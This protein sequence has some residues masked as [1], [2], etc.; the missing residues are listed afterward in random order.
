MRPVLELLGL[1]ALGC[2]CPALAGPALYIERGGLICDTEQTVCLRGNLVYEPNPRLL[3]LRARVQFAPGP[4]ELRILMTGTNRSGDRRY[5]PME[6][7]LRGKY[8]EIVDFKMIPD[9]PDVNAWEIDRV[10]FEPEP[11][12]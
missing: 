10:S 3:R 2:A 6:I 8:S 12:G 4:G 11:G 5:A 1:V 7:T 9:H